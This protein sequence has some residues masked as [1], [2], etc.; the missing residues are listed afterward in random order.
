MSSNPPL[1]QHFL[2]PNFEESSMSSTWQV[3]WDPGTRLEFR[4]NEATESVSFSR[5]W[6]CLSIFVFVVQ[7]FIQD[8]TEEMHRVIIHKRSVEFNVLYF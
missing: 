1:P 6:V 5:T 3:K 4:W 2:L 8:Q 7:T